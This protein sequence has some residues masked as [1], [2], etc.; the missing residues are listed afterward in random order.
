MGFV[1]TDLASGEI[2]TYMNS[3]LSISLGPEA[4]SKVLAFVRVHP[5]G[6]TVDALMTK[7]NLSSKNAVL[8][9]IKIL[10]EERKIRIGAAETIYPL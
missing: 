6:I 7:H 3:F 10:E 1:K 2:I 8:A 9:A 5:E 4:I